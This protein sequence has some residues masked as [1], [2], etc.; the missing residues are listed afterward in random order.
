MVLNCKKEINYLTCESVKI[1][2]INNKRKRVISATVILAL[3]K[4]ERRE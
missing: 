1:F 4:G 3:I 2:Q